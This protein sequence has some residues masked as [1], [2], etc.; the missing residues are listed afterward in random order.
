MKTFGKMSLICM[1]VFGMTANVSAHHGFSGKYDNTRP[2]WLQGTIQ[3]VVFQYPHAIVSL[4]VP[5]DETTGD[6][7]ASAPFLSSDPVSDPQY[8]GRTVRLEFPPISRFNSLENE[9]K[10]GDKVSVIVFRNCEQPHQLR[11]QW[12]RLTDGR[13]VARSGRVQTEV[14]GCAK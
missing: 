10:S 5:P 6:R 4:A 14:E 12:I 13:E 7:P 3:T 9:I 11:V 2:L 8:N 1:T